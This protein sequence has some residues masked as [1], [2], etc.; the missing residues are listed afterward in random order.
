MDADGREHKHYMKPKHWEPEDLAITEVQ[1]MEWIAANHHEADE[2]G[3]YRKVNRPPQLR[4]PQSEPTV[5]RLYEEDA[6]QGDE[7]HDD[8]IRPYTGKSPAPGE[9]AQGCDEEG[10]PA[11]GDPA[12]GCDEEGN[13]SQGC[14]EWWDLRREGMH[15]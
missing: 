9:P 5:D 12:Q 15:I 2:D 11:P 14:D 6:G 3:N 8:V 7:M 1:L 4:E 13:P 10:N